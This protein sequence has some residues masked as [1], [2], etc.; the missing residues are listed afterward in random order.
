[1]NDTVSGA[2]MLARVKPRLSEEGT[3][4]SLRPDLLVEWENL[5]DQL[6]E[7]ERAEAAGTQ[8]LATGSAKEKK[9]LAQKVVDLEAEIDSTAVRFVLRAMPKD[10]F[11]TLCEENPPRADDQ[12]DLM[13]GYNRVAVSDAAVRLCLVSPTFEDCLKPN[14]AHEECGSWQQ[15]T[16]V[17]NPG[18]WQDLRELAEKLN[19]QRGDTPKSLLASRILAKA[20]ST[21]KQHAAGG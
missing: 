6:S 4:I 15:F 9:A 21:S 5:T 16:S 13:V 8:R 11:Q 14:C 20:G 12:I 7:L 17:I 1:M 19:G 18:Q 10:R 3:F 2:E